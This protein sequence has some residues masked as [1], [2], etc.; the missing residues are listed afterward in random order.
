VSVFSSVTGHVSQIMISIPVDIQDQLVTYLEPVEKITDRIQDKYIVKV[1]RIAR[2]VNCRICLR[3]TNT[4]LDTV[5]WV[6]E[7][8]QPGTFD[9]CWLMDYQSK[10]DQRFVHVN[11]ICGNCA[12][13]IKPWLETVV[14]SSWNTINSQEFDE[15]NLTLPRVVNDI[16]HSYCLFPVN[17]EENANNH[18]F[19]LS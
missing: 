10:G 13:E 18:R 19:S 1:P 8:F 5:F 7:G 4:P 16:I 11:N 12:W 9:V 14:S 3:S 2:N 6:Q 17:A 15:M